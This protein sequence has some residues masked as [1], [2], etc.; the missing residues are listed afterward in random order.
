MFEEH[1]N[2]CY[3]CDIW[4]VPFSLDLFKM[5]VRTD[6]PAMLPESQ[7]TM[8]KTGYRNASMFCCFEHLMEHRRFYDRQERRKL[9]PYRDRFENR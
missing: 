4:F 9:F 6:N 5:A 1:Q 2:R 8:A 3:Y 7:N